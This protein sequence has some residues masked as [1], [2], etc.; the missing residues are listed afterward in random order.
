[1]KRSINGA[2]TEYTRPVLISNVSTKS[3]YGT[4]TNDGKGGI[5]WDVTTDASPISEGQA[6]EDAVR[7]VRAAQ[8]IVVEETNSLEY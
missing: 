7:C 8:D 5:P 1:M 3:N 2:I 6:A 4:L